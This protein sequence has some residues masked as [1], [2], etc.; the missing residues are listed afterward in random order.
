MLHE[1]LTGKIIGVFYTVYNTLGHGFLE[2]VYENALILELRKRGLGISQQVPIEVCYEGQLVG[3]YF[4]DMLVE[5]KVIVE[6][7]ALENIIKAHE[8]QLVNYLKATRMEVGLILNFGPEPQF[9]RKV[10]TNARKPMLRTAKRAGNFQ[11]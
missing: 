5:N 2:K 6:V 11:S 8:Y 4:A 7:K 1:D 9:K 10:F 3:E